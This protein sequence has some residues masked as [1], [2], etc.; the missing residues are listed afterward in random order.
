M[1]A[2]FS[3]VPFAVWKQRS[4]Q[5]LEE[6]DPVLSLSSSRGKLSAPATPPF[7][8]ETGPEQWCRAIGYRPSS[9]G[10]TVAARQGNAKSQPQGDVT[11]RWLEWLL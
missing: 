7:E 1:V 11:S 6:G 10:F 9:T 4:V 3:M 8:W 2:L 5:E